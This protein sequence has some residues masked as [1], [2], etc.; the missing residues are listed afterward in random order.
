MGKSIN[1]I[2]LQRAAL[3]SFNR[4]RP[5]LFWSIKVKLLP[6]NDS[7]RAYFWFFRTTGYRTSSRAKSSGSSILPLHPLRSWW[8]FRSPWDIQSTQSIEFPSV[9]WLFAIW[10]D[11]QT[12]W[13]E[14]KHL[15]NCLDC[16]SCFRRRTLSLSHHHCRWAS[17]FSPFF[18]G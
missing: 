7:G 10:S 11:P 15:M 18:L 16:W 8:Q 5:R 6:C 12:C 1:K 3:P 4:S 9:W 2:P 13:C 17:S 14:N